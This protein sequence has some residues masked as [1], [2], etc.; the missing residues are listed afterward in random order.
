MIDTIKERMIYI[1]KLMIEG[2]LDEELL[3]SL[4]LELEEISEQLK[5]LS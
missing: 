4:Y 5:T 3:S 1:T 2:N